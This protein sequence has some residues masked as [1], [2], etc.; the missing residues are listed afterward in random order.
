MCVGKTPVRF[1]CLLNVTQATAAEGTVPSMPEV[2]GSFPA[3][4]FTNTYEE[5]FYSYECVPSTWGGVG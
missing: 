5:Y 3:T 2:L 4:T 1:G